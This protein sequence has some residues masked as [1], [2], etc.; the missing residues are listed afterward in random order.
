MKAFA[1]IIYAIGRNFTIVLI[2]LLAEFTTLREPNWKILVE[3]HHILTMI[4]N[5]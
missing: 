2:M 1:R 4:Y 5:K 3:S